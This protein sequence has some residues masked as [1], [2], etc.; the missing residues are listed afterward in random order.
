MNEFFLPYDVFERHKK[1]GSFVNLA[2]TVLDVG[3]QLNQ[4]ANF[5]KP[6]KIVVANIKESQE[7]ADVIVEKSN[8]PFKNNSFS[9]VCAIDVIEHIPK[10]QRAAFLKELVRVAKRI[11]ILSFPIG[12]ERHKQYEAEIYRWLQDRG[13]DVG[14]LRQ[15]LKY[16]LPTREEINKIAKEANYKLF[17]SGDLTVSRLLF[18][19]FMFDPQIKFLRQAVYKTKL[20]FNLLTNPILYAILSNKSYSQKVV[21]VY[22]I[23]EKE[24]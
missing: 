4:L 12:T 18:K 23:I 21:R 7:Q 15:H 13:R 5:C 20:F 10:G 1:V 9:A 3:G 11:I 16:G 6:K 2:D 14:Y 22:L 17:Y 24:T 19:I 8:L